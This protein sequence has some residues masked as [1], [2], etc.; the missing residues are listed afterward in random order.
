MIP[1]DG[2][3]HRHLRRVPVPREEHDPARARRAATAAADAQ[4][5]CANVHRSS[6]ADAARA[7]QFAGNIFRCDIRVYRNSDQSRNN[8]KES[9]FSQKHAYAFPSNNTSH[10][11]W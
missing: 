7:G 8:N 11:F 3:E 5:G 6:A 1:A 2:R 9:D 10:M 4:S